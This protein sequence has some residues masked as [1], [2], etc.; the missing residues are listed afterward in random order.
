M[1]FI[2]Q[3]DPNASTT[4]T[5]AATAARELMRSVETAS[6]SSLYGTGPGGHRFIDVDCAARAA[7]DGNSVVF[8][9]MSEQSNEMTPIHMSSGLPSTILPDDPVALADSIDAAVAGTEPRAALARLVAANPRSSSVW[10]ALG[11]HGSDVVERYAAY[12]VGYHRGLDA[13]RANGWRGSGYVRWSEPGNRGFLRCLSGLRAC[14][15]AI[16]E[17]DEAERCAQFLGQLDPSGVPADVVATFPVVEPL[18]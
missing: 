15:E 6:T 3:A 5:T 18:G 4:N 16:G 11:D 8:D 7:D 10:A 9:D 12:R 14:A 1:V 17:A 13:L 2:S